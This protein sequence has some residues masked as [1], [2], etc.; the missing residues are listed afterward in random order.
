MVWGVIGWLFLLISKQYVN[1]YA[2]VDKNYSSI[3]IDDGGEFKKKKRKK[4]GLATL[5]Y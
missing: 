5:K 1:D 4:R 3:S 2:I